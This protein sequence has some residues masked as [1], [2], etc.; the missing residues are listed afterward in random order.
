MRREEQGRA[1]RAGKAVQAAVKEGVAGAV[2]ALNTNVKSRIC[3]TLKYGE[4]FPCRS[5]LV[6]FCQPNMPENS[7]SVC[8]CMRVSLS[9]CL[10]VYAC[11]SVC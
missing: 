8:I 4:V 1:G 6:V 7:Q 9:V 5:C 10:S 2:S 11:V 3:L